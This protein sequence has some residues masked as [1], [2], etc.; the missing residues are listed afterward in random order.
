VSVRIRE[1]ADLE[2]VIC[3]GDEFGE[4]EAQLSRRVCESCGYVHWFLPG[5]KRR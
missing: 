5:K 1:P 4:R 2:C 3:H